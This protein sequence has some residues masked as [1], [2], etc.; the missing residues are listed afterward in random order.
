M[1][2]HFCVTT[3]VVKDHMVLLIDHKKLDKWLPAGGHI[4]ANESPEDAA[5]REVREETGLEIEF[6]PM[7]TLTTAWGVQHN[8]I[9]EGHE[10]FDIIYLAKP[11]GGELKL[12]EG[13]TNGIQWFNIE[14]IED[15]SFRTFDKTRSWCSI[16]I[17]KY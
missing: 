8:I 10:H 9:K 7:N 17:D 16:A 15:P 14:Q 12:N 5:R 13:E 4:E 11:I 6:L 3:Y 1:D 2:K